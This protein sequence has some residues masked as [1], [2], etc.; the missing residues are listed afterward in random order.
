MRVTITDDVVE[1]L[2]DLLEREAVE[3]PVNWMGMQFAAQD[4]GHEVLATFVYEA[5]A[6]TYYEALRRAARRTERDVELP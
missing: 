1:Q 5:D 6:A 3:Q 4:H 2:A